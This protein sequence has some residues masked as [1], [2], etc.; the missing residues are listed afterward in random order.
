MIAAKVHWHKGH[1]DRTKRR[2]LAAIAA[3]SAK[4]VGGLQKYACRPNLYW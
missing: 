2:S 4:A 3:T 1:S